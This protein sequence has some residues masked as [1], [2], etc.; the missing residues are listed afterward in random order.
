MLTVMFSSRNG[1]AVLGR[2]LASLAAARAPAGGWKLVAVD[3]GSTDATCDILQSYAG[4]L[5]LTLLAEPQSG[6]NRALNRALAHGDGDLFVF[7]DDD[8]VVGR[9]WLVRWRQVADERVPYD[10]FAGVTVPL[11][12]YK[13]PLWILEETDL[14]IVFA[15]NGRRQEGPCDALAL[16]GT[17]MAIRARVFA[18]GLRFDPDI[19]PGSAPAYPMGSE[20][21]LVR[22][23]AAL[24]H[25]SWFANGPQVKH[26]I[27]AHQMERSA[28]LARGYRWGRGQ[29]HMRV[30]HS[31]TPERLHRKNLLRSRLYPLLMQFYSHKEAWARQ[32]EWAI[33]QGYEDGLR[34]CRGLAR[35]WL[36][37][38]GAPRI[39]QRFLATASRKGGQP[40]GTLEPEKPQTTG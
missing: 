23:L 17:N 2:T 20:T 5:P 10:L 40:R 8:V 38:D 39:A 26:I 27:R 15:A 37:D 24:G 3:N 16:F 19:G 6:K 21:E 22:R 31:Y 13:P 25:R 18:G 30:P 35:Q 29:A 9:D 32:W 4:R 28:I 7:C 1:G 36:L 12:P 34:E 33:D 14:G 11:W